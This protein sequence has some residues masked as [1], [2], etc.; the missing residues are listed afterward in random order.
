MKAN[1]FS[2][3]Y[4]F[5]EQNNIFIKNFRGTSFF[6]ERQKLRN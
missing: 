1:F 2:G 5:N 3:G 6:L 4:R